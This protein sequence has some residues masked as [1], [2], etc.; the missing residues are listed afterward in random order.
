[1]TSID[2]SSRVGAFTTETAARLRALALHGR[3][4][5]HL[6]VETGDAAAFDYACRALGVDCV[7]I[8]LA[9]GAHRAQPMTASHHEGDLARVLDEIDALHAALEARGLRVVRAKLEAHTDTPGLP[10]D[11]GYFEFHVK[12]RIDVH[13]VER[14]AEPRD[15]T[16]RGHADVDRLRAA[17]ALHGAHVSAN[18]RKPGQRFVTLRVY[19]ATIADAEAR[20]AALERAIADAGFALAGT[21]RE[22][23][24]ADTRIELD[25][26]WLD[27]PR[28]K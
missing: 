18:E 19:R 4:E 5:A 25:A 8:A 24:L 9:E 26:G 28:A 21:I 11:H 10:A 17:A 20:L 15:T 7:L 14:R 22:Y 23:T 6:T 12:I 13:D 3:F 27:G 16:P 1:V 2:Y